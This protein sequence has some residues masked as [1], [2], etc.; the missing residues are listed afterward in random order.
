MIYFGERVWYSMA[1]LQRRKERV[2]MW[3]CLQRLF[4]LRD[5][6]KVAPL[7]ST[8]GRHKQQ[9]METWGN[10]KKVFLE[11]D[12][13]EASVNCNNYCRRKTKM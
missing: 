9:Q 10:T 12:E 7:R 13:R 4:I 5:V 1:R 3:N 8:E 11:R 2:P 6:L